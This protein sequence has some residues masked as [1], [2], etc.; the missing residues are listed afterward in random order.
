MGI[1]LSSGDRVSII[2]GGPAGSFAALHMLEQ[3]ERL[4]MQLEVL[5][6]EPRNFQLPGPGGCNRCAGI[7]SSRLMRDLERLGMPLPTDVVQSEIRAYSVHLDHEMVRIDQPDPEDRIVSIYRGVGPQ[8][9]QGG[10][11]SSFDGYL[12]DKAC[13]RGAKWIQARAISVSGNEKP[14]VH[15]AQETFPT[16]LVI[17]ATGVNSRSPMDESFGYKPPPTETMAQDE[18]L[19][20][21][22]WPTDLVSAYF[23]KPAGLVFG[24]LIPKGRYVNIS[25]LGRGLG[26]KA[27]RDFIEAHELN[28]DLPMATGSLCGCTPRIAVGA[29]AR[30]FGDRWVAVGD[31]AITRLYKDGIGAA[32]STAE[33]AVHTA[34]SIGISEAD[35]KKGFAPFCE[36]ISKDNGY[37]RILFQLWALTLRSR[38]LMNIWLGVIQSEESLPHA[39]RIL[40]RIL[41]GMFTGSQ[42]YRDLLR[43]LFRVKTLLPLYQS[44]R[45]NLGK[46]AAQDYE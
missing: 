2:G 32:F 45:K 17:L 36:K 5:I 31:A 14:I 29:A 38:L 30:Y 11:A 37:G 44:V 21:Q 41:W 8:D 12:L 34:L 28:Q 18:F 26:T 10:Q 33:K 24:A 19:L 13:A 1:R 6:F 23:Q 3:S 46:R 35:F 27:I 42:P 7:L 22:G 25:L 16:D 15:T 4:G 43:S 39:Q 20:P 40:S 9:A